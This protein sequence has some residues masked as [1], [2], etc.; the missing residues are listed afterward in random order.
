[1]GGD[2]VN[3]F[4]NK[5]NT[6]SGQDYLFLQGHCEEG[7]FL[8]THL[9]GLPVNCICQLPLK[10]RVSIQWIFSPLYVNGTDTFKT[11]QLEDRYASFPS[12]SISWMLSKES[13]K[14]LPI[15]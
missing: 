15:P 11:I 7:I 13:P 3:G 4:R 5:E 10:T 14:E 8:K 9:P 6:N 2:G 1:V 12:P